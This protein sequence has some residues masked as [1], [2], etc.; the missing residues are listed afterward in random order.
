MDAYGYPDAA[1]AGF[2]LAVV[3]SRGDGGDALVHAPDGSVAAL[4]WESGDSYAF[5]E[6]A[7]PA[8]RWGAYAVTLPLP[9]TNDAEAAAYLAALLPELQR[10]WERGRETRVGATEA[11]AARFG[12]A[13]VGRALRELPASPFGPLAVRLVLL[14]GAVVALVGVGRVLG[15]GG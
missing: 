14:I 4:A 15:A 6:T 9:L 2:R 5:R 10:R 3:A 12:A 11:P 13:E 8:G 7:A 1:V